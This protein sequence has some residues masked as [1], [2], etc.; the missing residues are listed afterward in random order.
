MSVGALWEIFEWL[1]GAIGAPA[2]IV[3]DLTADTVG[4]VGAGLLSAWALRREVPRPAD[5]AGHS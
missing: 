5:G 2:D 3:F 4:A 1:I